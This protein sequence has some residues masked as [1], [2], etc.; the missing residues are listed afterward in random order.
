MVE[1]V[2]NHQLE[3]HRFI[4]QVVEAEEGNQEVQRELQVLVAGEMEMF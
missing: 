2:N 1:M 3:E 4:T